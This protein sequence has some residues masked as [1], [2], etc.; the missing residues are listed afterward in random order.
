MPRNSILHRQASG[1]LSARWIAFDLDD[2][3]H[4]FRRASRSAMRIVFQT[5]TDEYGI[6]QTRL[7]TAYAEILQEGTADCFVDG[8]T[9]REY[10]VERFQALLSKVRVVDPNFVDEL[11]E[12][13][14]YSLTRLTRIRP[15][16]RKLFEKLKLRGKKIA[17]VSEG[18]A[19]AQRK[20]LDRLGLSQFVDLLMTS[21]SEG[22]SK[23]D[24]LF[25]RLLEKTTAASSE[26]CVVG[27]SASRDVEPAL[28]LGCTVIHI[29]PGY[30]RTT[31]AGNI[32]VI[33]SIM[34]LNRVA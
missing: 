18:P 29:V 9:S 5:I 3:L 33:P 17:V 10:R 19:D 34:A 24:G 14:D 21:N 4:G 7:E 32:V 8:R 26:I 1:F 15:G 20:T 30:R 12:L 27:D 28:S 16:A 11:V 6:P 23:L 31:A 22:V 25:E 2:T 13:Y